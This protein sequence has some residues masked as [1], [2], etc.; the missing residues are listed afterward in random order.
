MEVSG[1]SSFLFLVGNRRIEELE[2]RNQNLMTGDHA[3][4]ETRELKMTNIQHNRY[5]PL[6]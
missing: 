3:H 4:V 2:T 6:L 5:L 1:F